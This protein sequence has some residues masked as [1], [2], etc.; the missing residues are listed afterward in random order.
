VHALSVLI[1]PKK[2]DIDVTLVTLALAGRR[3]DADTGVLNPAFLLSSDGGNDNCHRDE[4]GDED[5][6]RQC[7][8]LEEPLQ[9]PLF[10]LSG[11]DDEC[12]RIGASA[13]GYRSLHGAAKTYERPRYELRHERTEGRRLSVGR[14]AGGRQR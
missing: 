10:E 1:R 2:A 7:A 9:A 5:A 8:A 6:E 3:R 14:V 13:N 4:Q 12:R 11:H